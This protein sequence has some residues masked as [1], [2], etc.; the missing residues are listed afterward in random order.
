ML[1]YN[2]TLLYLRAYTAKEKKK[3]QDP[4]LCLPSFPPNLPYLTFNVLTV[5][6]D[7]YFH[8]AK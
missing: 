7:I 2:S 6:P 4:H 5:F 3:K 1:I 8:I